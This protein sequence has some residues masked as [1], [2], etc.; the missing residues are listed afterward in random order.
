MNLQRSLKFIITVIFL[1]VIPE[2]S[3]KGIENFS[4]RGCDTTLSAK[5][6]KRF[7]GFEYS[8]YRPLRDYSLINVCKAVIL[9]PK[10]EFW[11]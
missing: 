6:R 1:A 4:H 10:A 5:D 7:P 11:R 9:S 2:I 3:A 8:G